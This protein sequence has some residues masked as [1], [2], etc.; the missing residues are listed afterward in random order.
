MIPFTGADEKSLA[1]GPP[2][3]AQG[4]DGVHG[5]NAFAMAFLLQVTD[6]G[7][8]EVVERNNAHQLA[9]I[10]AI[11]DGEPRE[12]GVGHPVHHHA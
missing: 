9:G 11:D 10:V 3:R 5:Q 7:F 4:E 6:V 8:Q 12:A 2:S 1:S